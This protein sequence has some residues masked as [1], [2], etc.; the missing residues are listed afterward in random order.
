M[1]LLANFYNSTRSTYITTT[2][3]DSAFITSL[4]IGLKM[5]VFSETV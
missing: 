1:A 4:L 5:F 3:K 2:Y